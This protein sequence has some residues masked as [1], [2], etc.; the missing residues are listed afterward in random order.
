MHKLECNLFQISIVSDCSL[1]RLGYLPFGFDRGT[2]ERFIIDSLPTLLLC[3]D[4]YERTKCRSLTRKNDGALSDINNFIFENEFEL[5]EVTIPQ[6]A[7]NH[8]ETTMAN[9]HG[10]PLI[11]G[12]RGHNKLEMLDTMEN[13]PRWVEYEGTDYPYS[14][15]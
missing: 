10:F 6:S 15:M 3:F 9:Y 12:G 1:Q 13:P 8:F 4:Y 7:H 5:D 2:C 11:L 14:N